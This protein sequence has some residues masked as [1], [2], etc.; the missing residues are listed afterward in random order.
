[1]VTILLKDSDQ[2]Y[3]QGIAHLLVGILTQ[4]YQTTFRFLD[5][6]TPE[7]LSQADITVMALTNGESHLCIPE[8]RE[9]TKG[10]II[11]VQD[12]PPHRQRVL[13]V[14]FADF[15]FIDRHIG[16]AELHKMLAQ[17]LEKFFI[18]AAPAAPA[19]PRSCYGCMHQ[20]LSPQQNLI[21]ASMFYG[22]SVAQIADELNVS[23]KT[24]FTHKYLVMRKFNLEN[25]YELQRFM[26]VL[27]R[28]STRHSVFRDCLASLSHCDSS[29]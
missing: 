21:M 6:F 2:F 1:M 15:M 10:M 17:R 18:Y 5:G 14:C 20:R 22:K 12:K 26:Q 25:D 4:K 29:S 16:I 8:L 3:L 23:D 28:K 11:G 19:A 24:I 9:R 13:P 7:N 27:A